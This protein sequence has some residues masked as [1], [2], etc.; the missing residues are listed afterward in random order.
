MDRTGPHRVLLHTP[1]TTPP[2]HP[3]PIRPLPQAPHMARLSLWPRQPPPLKPTPTQ[4]MSIAMTTALRRR[5]PP[6]DSHLPQ[7]PALSSQANEVPTTRFNCTL[8]YRQPVSYPLPPCTPYHSFPCSLGFSGSLRSSFPM[9]CSASLPNRPLTPLP[10]PCSHRLRWEWRCEPVALFRPHPCGTLHNLTSNL[11]APFL[12]LI[13]HFFS[14]FQSLCTC[15]P[16]HNLVSSPRFLL[17]SRPA[18][19]HVASLSH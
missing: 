4:A 18:P 16:K 8:L 11:L 15:T 13:A 5:V 12:I 6:T 2:L 19:H 3:A 14:C 7:D 17:H 1:I 9:L 10:Y